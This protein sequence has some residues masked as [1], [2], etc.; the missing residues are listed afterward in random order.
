MANEERL[1]KIEE[2]M[3][4][5]KAQKQAILSRERVQERKAITRHLI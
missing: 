2:Q 1:K 5:L 3:S 4:K